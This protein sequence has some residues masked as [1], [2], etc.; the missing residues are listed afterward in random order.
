MFRTATRTPRASSRTTPLLR[1]TRALGLLSLALLGACASAPNAPEADVP[2]TPTTPAT[3]ARVCFMDYRE[4]RVFQL[5]NEAHTD[6]VALY[7]EMRSDTSTKV[8]NNEVMYALLAYLES[9]GFHRHTRSGFAPRTSS[10]FRWGAEVETGGGTVYMVV[11]DQ[12]PIDQR[13]MFLDC[14][15]NHVNLWSDVFQL[16]RVDAT[17]GEVFKKPGL[18][19]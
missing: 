18:P 17:P 14:Y 19:R 2:A 16:Q 3:P 13:K 12:T 8:T 11:G 15:M 9:S 1:T 4:G 6:R 5:V 10:S 7:S